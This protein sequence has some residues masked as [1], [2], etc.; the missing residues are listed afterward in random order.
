MSI[1]SMIADAFSKLESKQERVVSVLVGLEAKNIMDVD[2]D[3]ST[4]MDDDFLWDAKVVK[5][6]LEG[7][8][9][10]IMCVGLNGTTVIQSLIECSEVPLDVELEEERDVMELSIPKEIRDSLDK[11]ESEGFSIMPAYEIEKG[12]GG[13]SVFKKLENGEEEVHNP[14]WNLFGVSLDP[15]IIEVNLA[16]ELSDIWKSYS[17]SVFRCHSPINLLLGI[18]FPDLE[19]GKMKIFRWNIVKYKGWANDLPSDLI[20]FLTKNKHK[21]WKEIPVV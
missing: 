4:M 6:S 7:I 17:D 18:C 10:C 21:S 19:N 8:N 1:V 11:W 15:E 9:H 16:D 3:L 2:K 20:E 14:T 5:L 12:E 13:F